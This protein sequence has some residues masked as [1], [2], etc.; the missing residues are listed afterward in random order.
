M[1]PREEKRMTWNELKI[2]GTCLYKYA[3]R[4]ITV[5]FS[6]LPYSSLNFSILLNLLQLSTY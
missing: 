2:L 5:G 4:N 6:D 3:M 1:E